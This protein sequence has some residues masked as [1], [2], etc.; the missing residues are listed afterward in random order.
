MKLL[1]EKMPGHVDIPEDSAKGDYKTELSL[2]AMSKIRPKMTDV[3]ACQALTLCF[4]IENPDAGKAM[5][6]SGDLIA[7]LVQQ[8]DA[9]DIKDY[10]TKVNDVQHKKAEFLKKRGERVHR[11]FKKSANYDKKSTKKAPRW[12]AGPNPPY[13]V[14][15]VWGNK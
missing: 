15:R 12:L 6:V 3:E 1:L 8:A 5:C 13:V 4:Q 10:A 11:Y 9:K 2:L 14:S 7:E